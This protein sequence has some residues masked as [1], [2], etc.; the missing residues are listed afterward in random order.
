MGSVRPLH[1]E[2]ALGRGMAPDSR[3]QNWPSM[4]T[5]RLE[6]RVRGGRWARRAATGGGGRGHGGLGSLDSPE[7]VKGW[8]R[9]HVEAWL[10]LGSD[11]F[12]IVVLCYWAQV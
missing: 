11:G 8:Y 12:R 7:L 2:C 4:G 5:F 3:H 9:G 10:G 1:L 6:G